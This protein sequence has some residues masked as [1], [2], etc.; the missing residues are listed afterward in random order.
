MG[1]NNLRLILKSDGDVN[2]DNNQKDTSV[3][4]TQRSMIQNTGTV[5]ITGYLLMKIQKLQGEE[6]SAGDWADYRTVI[7]ETTARTILR[8]KH[9]ALDLIWNPYNVKIDE[10]GR[11][12]V[13][14]A[15]TDENGNVI[16]SYGEWPLSETYIFRVD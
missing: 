1:Y 11:Y 6:G 16:Q 3:R 10:S 13:Y 15:F 4:V 2:K 8:D 14:G 7:N 9:L 12:R 5:N